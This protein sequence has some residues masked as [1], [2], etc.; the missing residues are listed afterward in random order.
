MDTQLVGRLF[1]RIFLDSPI[2]WPL[3]MILKIKTV[4]YCQKTI[5]HRVLKNLP[6]WGSNPGHLYFTSMNPNVPDWIPMS[7]GFL[8]TYE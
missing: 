3:Y 4:Y 5:T 2:N 6:T 7:G 1:Q 8:G